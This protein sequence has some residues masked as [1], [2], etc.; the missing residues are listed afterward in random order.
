MRKHLATRH[1]PLNIQK[2]PKYRIYTCQ[3]KPINLR[4]RLSWKVTKGQ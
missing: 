3:Y 1:I 2:K 4:T